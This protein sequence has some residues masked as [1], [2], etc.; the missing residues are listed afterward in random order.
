AALRRAELGERL[1]QRM[2]LAAVRHALDGLDLA[3]LALDRQGEAGQ[4]GLTVD[5]HRAGAALAELAAVLGAG[6]LEV[7]AQYLEERLVDGDVHLAL[8]TVDHERHQRFHGTSSGLSSGI[9]LPVE[10]GVT[11]WRKSDSEILNSD[12]TCQAR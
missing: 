2:Q 4:D 6:E 5:E 9:G 7:L 12:C 10:R 11:Y 3:A 1:L 8:L